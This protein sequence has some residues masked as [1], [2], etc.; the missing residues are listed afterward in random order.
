MLL[1]I[2]VVST[3]VRLFYQGLGDPHLH[4]NGHAQMVTHYS[5]YSC[6]PQGR[7]RSG[8]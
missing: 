6:S 2:L 1:F 4:K 7:D 8:W 5:Q 3:N